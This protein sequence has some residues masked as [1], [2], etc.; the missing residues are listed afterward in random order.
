MVMS[1][2]EL[3]L[4]CLLVSAALVAYVSRHFI[5]NV[6]FVVNHVIAAGIAHTPGLLHFVFGLVR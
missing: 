4:I 1:W 3:L 2:R 5:A 6:L